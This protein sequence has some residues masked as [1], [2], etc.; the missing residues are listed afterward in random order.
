MESGDGNKNKEMQNMV[1]YDG[2][3]DGV[4]S[5]AQSKK[6]KNSTLSTNIINDSICN[7]YTSASRNNNN[8]IKKVTNTET[9]T[10]TMSTPSLFLTLRF[11]FF[12]GIGFG[13]Y[14]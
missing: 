1:E 9:N 6:R 11:D 4:T 2:A 13:F 8:G 14:P 7:S 5:A 3:E 10:G 12:F